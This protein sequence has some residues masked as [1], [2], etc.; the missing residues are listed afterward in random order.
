M[1]KR[2]TTREPMIFEMAKVKVESMS[3]FLTPATREK[4]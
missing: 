2:I 4:S 3:K 1:H